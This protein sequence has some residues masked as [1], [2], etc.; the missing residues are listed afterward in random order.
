MLAGTK[1]IPRTLQGPLLCQT[2]CRPTQ[3]PDSSLLGGCSLLTALEPG[4]QPSTATLGPAHTSLSRQ[5]LSQP[6]VP[7]VQWLLSLSVVT[8][9]LT[10]QAGQGPQA[11]SAIAPISGDPQWQNRC[12]FHSQHCTSWRGWECQRP[13][14]TAGFSY[15]FML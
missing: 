10:L 5:R 6:P 12:G 3:R 7:S 1:A 13:A 9:S 8:R 15:F 14:R 4:T 2:R 11:A